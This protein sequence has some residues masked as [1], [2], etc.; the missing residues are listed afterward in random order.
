MKIVK[1]SISLTET[2]DPSIF[3]VSADVEDD[4]DSI[5]VVVR[6]NVN[7]SLEDLKNRLIG[8]A[9]SAKNTS[10]IDTLLQTIKDS[11]ID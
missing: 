5:S 8:A 9:E 3:S 2:P 11:I 4:E 6:W 10:T 7:E 1:R